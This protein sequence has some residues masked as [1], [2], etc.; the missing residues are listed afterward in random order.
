MLQ[1]RYGSHGDFC[2]IAL[3]PW[4]VQEMYDLTIRAFNLA[5][6]YRVPAFVLADEGV[7]HLRESAVLHKNVSLVERNRDPTKAPFGHEQPDGVPPM[8]AFGDG[9][10]LMV[11]GS[12][13]DEWGYRKVDTPEPH[14]VLVER[15]N[16]KVQDHTDEI[17]EVDCHLLDDAEIGL[18][19]YGFTGRSAI[20]AVRRLRADGVRAGLLRLKTIWPFPERAVS[21]LGASVKRILVPELNRGQ[22]A[23]VVQQHVR[24][25]VVSLTQTDGEVIEPEAIVT[26]AREVLP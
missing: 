23:G 16:R 21:A 15:L 9:A 3:S 2:P 7:G 24:S 10:A 26:R 13:H 11:T 1:V 8:P 20:A 22:I 12:T 25:D 18:V 5:E 6:Q 17:A 4:S 19:A 14:R